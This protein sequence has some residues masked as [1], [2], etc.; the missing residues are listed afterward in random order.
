MNGIAKPANNQITVKKE[1]DFHV[2]DEPC[3]DHLYICENVDVRPAASAEVRATH[4]FDG[5]AAAIVDKIQ[6]ELLTTRAALRK[7]ETKFESEKRNHERERTNWKQKND[8]L[9]VKNKL[10]LAQLKQFMIGQN[11]VEPKSSDE[12]SGKTT[13]GD[14][15]RESKNST[16]SEDDVY[17]VQKILS[18]KK[19]GGTE[20]Y[21]VRWKGY[22]SKHD[23][24]EQKE[25]LNCPKLLKKYFSGVKN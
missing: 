2:K 7:I 8:A 13:L 18:H 9:S 20:K 12:K 1:F 5:Q 23:T 19:I 22:D 25:N 3:E 16:S 17:E 21:L 10:L 11:R 24:W 14:S 15:S 6:T 4:N